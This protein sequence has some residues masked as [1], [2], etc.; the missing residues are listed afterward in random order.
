[1][2]KES[3]LGTSSVDG[4]DDDKTGSLLV[5][6]VVVVVVGSG[7]SKPLGPPYNS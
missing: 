1:V 6:V 4:S 2:A 5:V 7:E 3:C